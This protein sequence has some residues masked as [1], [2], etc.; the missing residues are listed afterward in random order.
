[1]FEINGFSKTQKWIL[2]ILLFIFML[3]FIIF[4]YELIDFHNDYV[5]STTKNLEWFNTHNCKKYFNN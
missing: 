2:I 5:C 3:L 1:M 4:I